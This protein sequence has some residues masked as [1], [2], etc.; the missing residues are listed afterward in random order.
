MRNMLKL[1]VLVCCAVAACQ[2]FEIGTRNVIENSYYVYTRTNPQSPVSVLPTAAS[3]TA[4]TTPIDSN[5]P[6]VILIHGQSGS[7]FTSLNPVVKDAIL[8]LGEHNVIVVD[9]SQY[10]SL[11]Y[12]TA[13]TVVPQVAEHLVLFV[14]ELIAATATLTPPITRNDIHI[15][16]F[17]LGAHVAGHAGRLLTTQPPNIQQ[18][19]RITGLDPS[20]NG[21]GLNSGRLGVTDARYVEVIHTDG[22]GIFANGIGVSLGNIDFFANGG[23]N[24]PGCFSNSCSHERA[25]ELF[26]ASMINPKLVGYPCTSTTQL[27]LNRCNGL[28]VRLGTNELY[29][30]GSGMYRANTKRSFPF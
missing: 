30:F 15:V 4:A 5:W 18:V 25:Y 3:I 26:A 23:S 24:Q 20:G 2:G 7:V 28:P 13:S 21:W 22:S 16:G 8:S 11:G 6:T 29:K 10:A 12:A 17:D 1:V 27:N 14:E 9:W 19:A